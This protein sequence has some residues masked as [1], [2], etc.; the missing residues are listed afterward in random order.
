MSCAVFDHQACIHA[1]H[2]ISSPSPPHPFPYHL[3]LSFYPF[4]QPFLQLIEGFHLLW[5]SFSLLTSCPSLTVSVCSVYCLYFTFQLLFIYIIGNLLKSDV[6][7]KEKTEM[8]GQIL[9]LCC[10]LAVVVGLE[11][12]HDS[13]GYTGGGSYPQQVQ[14]CRADF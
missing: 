12:L 6:K 11:R 1:S 10:Y 13:E 9:P 3:V 2:W 8:V 14:P 5:L 4:L 7:E